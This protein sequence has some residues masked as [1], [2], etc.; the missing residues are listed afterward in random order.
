MSKSAKRSRDPFIVIFY[1][2]IGILIIFFVGITFKIAFSPICSADAQKVCVIDTWSIA[3]LTAAVF[4]IAAALLTF[5]GAFAVAY[6]WASLDQKVDDQVKARTNELIEQR[7]QAQETKFQAQIEGNVKAFETQIA[8]LETKF[9]AQIADTLKRL[10]VQIDQ[11]KGNFEF[12]RREVLIV[13]MMFPPWEVDAWAR[14]LLLVDPSSEVAG[15]MVRSYLQE[16]DY[17]L[18]DPSAP[19]KWETVR[20]VPNNDPLYYW[21]KAL[22]W[23]ELVK[24]QN[25]AA[26][27]SNADRQINQRRPRIEAYEKQK[28]SR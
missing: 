3:G 20:I 16:V 25:N 7:I 1:V 19:S 5:L 27:L 8:Q 15:R 10:D 24:R 26:Y 11:L 6:W 18:P 28:G 21:N 23:R 2:F 12:I 17:Q 9:Q 13:T 4:G 14:E 22:E